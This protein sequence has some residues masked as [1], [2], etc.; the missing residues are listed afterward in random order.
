MRKAIAIGISLTGACS[1]IGC[2]EEIPEAEIGDSSMLVLIS[3]ED[4]S[5]ALHASDLLSKELER[6]GID[7]DLNSGGGII[8]ISFVGLRHSEV[9]NLVL[10]GKKLGCRIELLESGVSE[11]VPS[12]VNP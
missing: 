8:E 5:V 3:H 1:L 7:Y 6:S 11:C 10:D 2:N 12:L 4:A 9:E